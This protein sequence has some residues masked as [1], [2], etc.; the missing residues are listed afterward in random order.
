MAA[1]K[2]SVEKLV[3]DYRVQCLWFLRLDHMPETTVEILRVLSLVQR[4]GDRPAYP[5]A[6][7]LKSWLSRHS[8]QPS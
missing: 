7:E 4:H 6:E 1:A 8:R 2:D 5:R 3:E